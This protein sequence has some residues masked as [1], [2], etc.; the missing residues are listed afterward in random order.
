M[1][2]GGRHERRGGLLQGRRGDVLQLAQGWS[3]STRRTGRWRSWW[4]TSASKQ[5]HAAGRYPSEEYEA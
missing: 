3:I 1:T 5:G 4:P 2:I